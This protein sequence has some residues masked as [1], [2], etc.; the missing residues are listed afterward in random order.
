[1]RALTDSNNFRNNE[2]QR[3]DTMETFKIDRQFV[4]RATNYVN[5]ADRKLFR[6]ET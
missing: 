1:M 2:A 6:A 4:I 3:P 5:E